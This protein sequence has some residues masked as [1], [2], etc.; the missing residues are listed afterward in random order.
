LG[1][2]AMGILSPLLTRESL[3]FPARGKS[4]PFNGWSKASTALWK[5]SGVSGATLHDIRRT[6]RTVHARIGTPPHVAERLVN[7]VSSRTAVEVIYDRHTYL[8]EMRKAVDSY[9]KFLQTILSAS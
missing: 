5:A 1:N 6:Y 8:P 7:H 4:S 9:E 3:L 2:L